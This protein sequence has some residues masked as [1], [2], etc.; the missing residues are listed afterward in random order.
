[1][2]AGPFAVEGEIDDATLVSLVAF[3]RS[4]PLIPGVPEGAVPRQVAAAP[5]D[6]IAQRA[7]DIF[8]GLRTSAYTG[9]NVTV[10]QENGK[11]RITHVSQWI[12]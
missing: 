12:V 7:N 5:I 10:V 8:V 6:V 9:Q 11:W 4:T 3:I 2:S 1:M